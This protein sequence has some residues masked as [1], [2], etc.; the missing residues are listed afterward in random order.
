MS[1]P[2]SRKYM[3]HVA[4]ANHGRQ[5]IHNFLLWLVYNQGT[6]LF[7]LKKNKDVGIRELIDQY[8]DINREALKGE[9]EWL[10]KDLKKK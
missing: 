1:L 8:Y 3:Y 4:G 9:R 2:S 5:I 7:P 10:L 6:E